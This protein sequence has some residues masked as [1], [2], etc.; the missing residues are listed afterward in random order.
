MHSNEVVA[1]APELV[2]AEVAQ[3]LRNYVLSRELTQDQARTHLAYYVAL[4][5]RL[6]SLR[7][8]APDAVEV[9]L[10]SDLSA[11]DAFYVCVAR[12]LDATLVTA[13]RRLA[14]HHDRVA[15]VA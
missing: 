14:E 12:A 4:P 9:A 7:R 10:R 8:L 5:L 15:L 13:D 11:Y 3:A 6:A 2:Y 1:W